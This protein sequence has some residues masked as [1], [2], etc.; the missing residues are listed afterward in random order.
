MPNAEEERS[1]VFIVKMSMHIMN[2]DMTIL[3]KMH[4]VLS[5]ETR[6]ILPPLRGVEKHRLLEATRKVDKVMN[7]IELRNI[8]ELNDLVYAG[9][10]SVTEML[11]LK[12]RKSTGMD[13]WWRRIMETQVKQLNKDIGQV[14]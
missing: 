14:P 6:E 10:V 7:K 11:G 3:E 8:T 13:L 5:K 1:N 12:N 9:A 4:I 2:E